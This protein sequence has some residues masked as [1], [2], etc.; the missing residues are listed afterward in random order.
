MHTYIPFFFNLVKV[1]FALHRLDPELYIPSQVY[2]IWSA[3]FDYMYDHVP[4]GVYVI[5]MHPYISGRAHR[6]MMVERLKQHMTMRPGLDLTRS[7]GC[8]N[9]IFK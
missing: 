5:M 2:E 4:N 1:E 3:E 6:L 8:F 7:G 9:V